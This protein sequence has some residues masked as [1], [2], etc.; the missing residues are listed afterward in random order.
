MAAKDRS[1]NPEVVLVP[2]MADIAEHLA[3]GEVSAIPAILDEAAKRLGFK[4]WLEYYSTLPRFRPGQPDG[5]PNHRAMSAACG[6]YHPET[7][8]DA[9][10]AWEVAAE[11]ERATGFEFNEPGSRIYGT[12]SLDARLLLAAWPGSALGDLFAYASRWIGFKCHLDSMATI[13]FPGGLRSLRC[14]ARSQ[15]VFG[16]MKSDVALSLTIDGIVR[17]SRPQDGA[18]PMFW[19]KSP[20]VRLIRALESRLVSPRLYG[21]PSRITTYYLRTMEGVATWVDGSMINSNTPGI[22]AMGANLDGSGIWSLPPPGRDHV[23]QKK[24]TQDVTTIFDSTGRPVRLEFVQGGAGR[25]LQLEQALPG[26]HVMYLMR[27]D[28]SGLEALL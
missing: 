2:L 14:G 27:H 17:Y 20:E 28:K 11:E 3:R 18:F 13:P 16:P 22:S 7:R 6:L 12:W 4:G 15:G 5:S 24:V 19:K 1:R 10:S 21:F 8:A 26:G 23:R 25:P 9:V